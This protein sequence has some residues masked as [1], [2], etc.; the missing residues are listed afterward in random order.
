MAKTRKM[1]PTHSVLL[2]VLLRV[3]GGE[4][5]QT[6]RGGVGTYQRLEGNSLIGRPLPLAWAAGRDGTERL[7][8]AVLVPQQYPHAGYD[9]VALTNARLAAT[10]DPRFHEL[11]RVRLVVQGAAA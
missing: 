7:Y 2:D 6:Y 9:L 5:V 3:G 8:P 11:C 4:I 1:D 10:L